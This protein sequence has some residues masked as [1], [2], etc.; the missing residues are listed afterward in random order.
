MYSVFTGALAWLQ[1]RH[2]KIQVLQ[3]QAMLKDL[4]KPILQSSATVTIHIHP[5]S[6]THAHF[7]ANVWVKS[8]YITLLSCQ[9][10]STNTQKFWLAPIKA[11]INV[12]RHRYHLHSRH[13]QNRWKKVYPS[14]PSHLWSTVMKW[15]MSIGKRRLDHLKNQNLL[16]LPLRLT[17]QTIWPIKPKRRIKYHRNKNMAHTGRQRAF[18]FDTL[19]LSIDF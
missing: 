8:S 16:S 4:A 19:K 2:S 6:Y 11:A 9:K 12:K 10:T 15:I 13:R 1:W 7:C 5:T 17:F 3:H 18:Y 14:K